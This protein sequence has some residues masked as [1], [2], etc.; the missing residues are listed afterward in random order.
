MSPTIL[1]F[2]PGELSTVEGP[3]KVYGNHDT[4]LSTKAFEFRD[5]PCPPRSVMVRRIDSKSDQ[6]LATNTTIS[7]SELV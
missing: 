4:P 5:L 3:L 2:Y 6:Y 7:G 1:S